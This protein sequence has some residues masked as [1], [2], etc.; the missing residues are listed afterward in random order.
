VKNFERTGGGGALRESYKT[1]KTGYVRQ[2]RPVIQDSQDSQDI[3]ES[4]VITGGGGALLAG[5][6]NERSHV[7]RLGGYIRQSR[8]V[9]QDSQDRSYKTVKAHK[10]VK[11]GYIRQSRQP[12][13]G[14]RRRWRA[15]RARW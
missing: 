9:I 11:T 10:T 4:Q 3:K 6:G 5:D 14:Y 1:V 15:A 7:L 13:R 8:Q 12:Q 2:S